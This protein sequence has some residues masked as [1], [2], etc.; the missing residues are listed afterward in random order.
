METSSPPV[1]K[2]LTMV[3]F[4][5]SCVGLLLFLWLSFGGTI[6]LNPQGYRVRVSFPNAQQLAT[7]ADVRIAGVSVGKVVGKSLDPSGNLTMAT[8]ELNNQYAP[9]HR[10]ATAILR[11]KTILGETYVEL[12]P[13]TPGAPALPD[14]GLLARG[15]VQ[16]AVQLGQIFD[17]FDPT[18]RHAFQVWQQQLGTAVTGNG[19]NLS[20]VLGNLPAFAADATDVLQVLDVEQNAVV[21]LSQNGA[22]VFSALGGNQT[23]LRNLITSADQVFTTTAQNNA[24]LARTFQVF[25]T[26]LNETRTTMSRL[27]TFA[28]DTD[29]LVKQLIPVAQ[30][31]T[32]TLQA[33]DQLSPALQT[34][35][36]KLGPLI[37]ASKRGLPAYADVLR[38]AT[39]LFGSLGPFLS[40]L[41]PILDWLSLHQQLIS[42]F[43]SN[44]AA[45][46]AATTT[47]FGGAGLTCG[48]VPCGHYLRQFQ[49]TST[50][51]FSVFANRDTSNRGNT[52]PPSLWLAD[53]RGLIRGNLPAWDCANTG[54]EH[55]ATATE[56]A[57]WVAPPLPGAARSSTL[58]HI[59]QAHYP[60]R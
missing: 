6:P 21:G 29:P 58:P 46:T 60:S 53:P 20:N 31:L 26:F 50:E 11:V 10:D 37:T 44:G 45:G 17:A 25:P 12:R 16:P 22:T 56:P 59:L 5:L 39:P 52:Y 28:E 48:G 36:T 14:D 8:L 35:F 33:V 19:Q 30:D 23:A 32:P 57:C 43:I 49:P 41:N 7:Q 2:V 24:A 34:L 18:T 1:R 42:D 40:Q 15:Q 3:L 13:G 4:A 51:T 47:A 38:G 9:I 55:P 54:G 27:Q